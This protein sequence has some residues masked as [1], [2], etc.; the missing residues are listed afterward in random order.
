M[1]SLVII[2][3]LQI[4]ISL[5]QSVKGR[6]RCPEI[7]GFVW[8]IPNSDQTLSIDRPLLAALDLL[9]LI[10]PLPDIFGYTMSPLT[11]TVK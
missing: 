10:Y 5:I 4:K 3:W 11:K 2:K 9:D 6:T 8:S 7:Q 1:L